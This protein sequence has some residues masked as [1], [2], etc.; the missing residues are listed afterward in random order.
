MGAS[1]RQT[2]L[3]PLTVGDIA[4]PATAQTLAKEGVTVAFSALPAVE[5]AKSV[6]TDVVKRWHHGVL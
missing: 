4:D 2:E 1:R 5:E 3:P 6:G